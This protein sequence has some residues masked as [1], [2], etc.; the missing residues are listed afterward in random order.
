MIIFIGV[1]WGS[2]YLKVVLLFKMASMSKCSF[3][4]G[5]PP[6]IFKTLG[7]FSI[8][9]VRKVYIQQ[10]AFCIQGQ[11]V[12]N[13]SFRTQS[14]LRFRTQRNEF[15]PEPVHLPVPCLYMWYLEQGYYYNPL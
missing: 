15:L 2:E 11:T 13:K 8:P 9:T 6:N 7:L 12:V 1:M 10:P 4:I 5:P 14:F 3:F